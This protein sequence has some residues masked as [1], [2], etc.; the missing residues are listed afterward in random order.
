VSELNAAARKTG[1]SRLS[2]LAGLVSMA[3]SVKGKFK[4]VITAIDK[5][6]KTLKSDEKKDLETKEEC[7]KDRMS[8]TRKALLAGGDID[9]KTDAIRKLESEI[10]DLEESIANLLA[11]KKKVKE[12]L[13]K[14]TDLRKRENEDWKVTNKDDTQAAS[15]VKDASDVL[16][17]FYS[18]SFKFVQIASKAPEVVDGEAP[19]PPPSTWGKSYGG[20][21]GEQT[22]IMAILEMVRAD[23]LKDLEKAKEEEGNSLKEFKEMEKESIQ[24]MKDLQKEADKQT[25]TKGKKET[26][27]TDTIKQ[28]KTKHGE[29]AGLMKT[30]KDISPDCEYYAVN[31]KMRVSNRAIEVDGLNKAKAIL[32]GGSFKK[33]L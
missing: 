30:M 2:A 14:A 8:N 33:M 31:Y 28:R 26:E 25:G 32:Q 9:D 17:K 4:S 12:E 23:I 1:D 18:T 10:K 6:I 3:P 27:R 16:K 5:M 21:Q 19:P 29:W 11:D 24:E 13:A 22:G 7:E 15:V 20:K